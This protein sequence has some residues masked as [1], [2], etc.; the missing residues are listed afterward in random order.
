MT[1]S[2]TSNAPTTI[3]NKIQNPILTM[4]FILLNI[5]SFLDGEQQ[6]P[7]SSPPLFGSNDRHSKESQLSFSP[8]CEV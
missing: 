5:L 7:R 3:P 6:L 8:A 2:S 4:F 1:T